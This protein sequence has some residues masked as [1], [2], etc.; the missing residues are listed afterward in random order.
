MTKKNAGNQSTVIEV[1]NL[2]DGLVSRLDMAKE[3]NQGAEAQISR[4]FP[5]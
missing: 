4:D 5:N 1:K 3:K 2:F